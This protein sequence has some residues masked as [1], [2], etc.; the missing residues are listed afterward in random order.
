MY[1]NC[2]T[3][4]SLRYGT[5]QTKTLVEQ[6]KAMGVTALALT[7]INM[8]ADLWDF[9]QSC[10]QCGIQPVM[11]IEFR[12]RHHCCYI[13]LARSMQGL[14]QMN[15]FL[16]RHLEQE[17]SFPQRAPAL[18]DVFVIYPWGSLP[19]E[20]LQA[21]ELLGVRPRELNKLFRVNTEAY[22]DKLVILQPVT[23]RDAGQYE[24]HTLLRAIDQNLLIT[25]LPP[26]S[27]AR[28]DEVMMPPALLLE[29]FAAYPHMVQN[30]L[31]IIQACDVHVDLKVNRNKLFFTGSREGDRTKLR[32]LAMEGMLRR[33]GAGHAVALERVEK[34]LRTIDQQ[35]F[36][37][38]FLITWDIIDYARNRRGYFHVGRGSGANSIVAYCLDITDV[39]PVVLDLYFERFLNPYRSSP[40]DFDIDFSWKDRDDVIRYVFEKYGPEHTALLGTV[41]TFQRNATI[42]ELG[43]VYGLPKGEIDKILANPYQTKLRADDDIH[44]KIWQYSQEIEDFPNHLSIHAG[45]VLISEAPIRQ[46]CGTHLPPKG[47]VTAQLDMHQAEAIGLHK[48]DILSQ[49][50]LGHI[51]DAVE[52]IRHNRGV[53]IDIH[54]VKRFMADPKVQDA[55]RN[56]NTIGC[57]YIESPAMRQLLKKLGCDNYLTLVAASSIIRPGVAQ[58]GMMRQY[59]WNYH[60]PDLVRY[61]HP[62]LK[63]LLQETYGVMVY[64][65]DVIKVA[66]Y[67]ADLELADADVL[68]R[69]MAGKYRGAEEFEQIQRQF[70][71]N[72][73]RKGHEEEVIVEVWRQI[74]SF[75]NFSFSKAHSASFAVESYQSLFLKTYFPAEFMVA[76]INN[77]G[78]FYNRELYFREL[79]QSGAKVHPPCVNN[80]DEHT[81]ISGHDVHIGFIHVEGLETKL[82]AQLLRSRY[83]HGP[84]ES[85]EDF[86]ARI[87][88]APA[89][90]ELLI[91]IGA[92]N[93]TGLTR[94]ELLWK[95]SP[96]VRTRPAH[97]DQLI[98]LFKD[99]P[100]DAPLP[101]LAYH[102]HEDA[103]EEI[104]LLGFSVDSPFTVLA[105]EQD[106]YLPVRALDN[107]EGE[108]V[109]MLGYLV[110]TKLRRTAKGEPM[111]FGTFLDREGAFLDTVHFPASLQRFPFQKGGFYV[112]EGKVVKEFGV[113]SV[114]VQYMRKVGWMEDKFPEV[115]NY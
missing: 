102:P 95:S 27:L 7:N 22:A 1:L 50:G 87:S 103:F 84:F 29:R 41:S 81:N 40:P 108:T 4:F 53:E 54:D 101:R 6:A 68:R 15:S 74:A 34:E 70:F 23:L 12:N 30:T 106:H 37:G 79:Q 91:R 76:V 3:S 38:Y 80:S 52:L 16:S 88:P 96:L 92:F 82:V 10:Q 8:T 32:E 112:M 115:V 31:R 100:L 14:L 5:L 24:L 33:Y 42:R 17:A 83:H 77:F 110:C 105:H 59:I 86:V 107:K 64:Q 61:L 11:G 19:M 99:P 9:V 48:F 13:M 66:H 85:L 58:S 57:F 25:Q 109:V 63:E 111:C 73:R 104:A 62:M 18:E 49:R 39:D 94:K 43:K 2:K 93:F 97:A 89:Q 28:P 56:V 75:A 21:H 51:R 35:D 67:F 90:L 45:G 26:E 20:A 44:R 55:L 36:N 72:C 71:D 46:Y 69:A 78:G 113:V 47:F 60:N 65:E 98:S 114:D